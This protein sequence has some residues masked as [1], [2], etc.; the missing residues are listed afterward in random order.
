M[1]QKLNA[2]LHALLTKLE[3]MHLKPQIVASATGQRTS[4]VTEMTDLECKRLIGSLQADEE[5]EMKPMRGKL[6][7]LLCLL[8]YVNTF[9]NADFDRINA[10]VQQIGTNNPRKQKVF[11][12]TKSELRAV[13]NQVTVRY[14]AT[15]TKI[16]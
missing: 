1:D 13:L 14:K 11:G 15:I 7:H 12:L 6:I 5:R 16:R 2:Q 4:T 8:G 10:F 3:I 9:G